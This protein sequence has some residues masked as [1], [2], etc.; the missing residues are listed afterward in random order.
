[1]HTPSHANSGNFL[2]FNLVNI[3][4]A[5]ITPEMLNFCR[6]TKCEGVLSSAGIRF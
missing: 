1:M 5:D 4:S 6:V 3:F 2:I